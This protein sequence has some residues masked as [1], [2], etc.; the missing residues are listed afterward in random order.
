MRRVLGVLAVVTAAYAVMATMS[1]VGAV[2][3]GLPAGRWASATIYLVWFASF[4]LAIAGLFLLIGN[5]YVALVFNSSAFVL[6]CVGCIL[7]VQTLQVGGHGILLWW[8]ILFPTLLAILC[9][10]G[11]L[12]VKR[13]ASQ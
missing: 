10:A 5:R 13:E 8:M 7:A 4:A 11:S 3:S 9:V 1:F 12:A 2:A 6:S